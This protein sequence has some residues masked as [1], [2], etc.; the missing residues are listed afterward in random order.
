MEKIPSQGVVS[1]S[2]YLKQL[3]GRCFFHYYHLDDS[4][5]PTRPLTITNTFKTLELLVPV[6]LSV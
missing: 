6:P 1:G 2:S 3:P 4:G 5:L